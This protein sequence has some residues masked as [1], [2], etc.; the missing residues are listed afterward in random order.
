MRFP[1]SATT[2]LRAL[3]EADAEELYEVV[4]AS[5]GYL[6]E[7]MPWA[8]MQTLEGTRQFISSAIAQERSHEGFQVALVDDGRIIGV[9]GFHALDRDN[10]SIRI[11]YWLAEAQQGKGLMSAAV[12][13]LVDYAFDELA[14]NRIELRAAPGNERSKALAERLGFQF[15]GIL[16]EAECFGDR[17][18]DLAAYSLL[19]RE[20]REALREGAGSRSVSRT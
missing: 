16:R 15:E 2:E 18:R 1:I 4:A 13:T 9:V 14:I 10:H 17:H 19:V 3:V 20:R 12:A 8:P 7:W 6:A 11:G 5:R